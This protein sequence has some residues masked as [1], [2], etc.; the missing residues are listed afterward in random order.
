MI[1]KFLTI[2]IF[3]LVLF[4]TFTSKFFSLSF[5]SFIVLFKGLYLSYINPTKYLIIYKDSII[6]IDGYKKII[7]DLFLHILPFIFIY[8]NYGLEPVFNNWKLIPSLLLLIFYLLLYNPSDIYHI[9]INEITILSIFSFISY[10]IIF[11]IYK[12]MI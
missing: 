5:L 3:I 12:K 6:V 7:V 8:Y 2:W 10:L 4:H 9:H 1:Y 11:N